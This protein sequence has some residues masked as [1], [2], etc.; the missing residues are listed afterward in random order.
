MNRASA[1]S[2]A[3]CVALAGLGSYWVVRSGGPDRDVQ[4]MMVRSEPADAI[5]PL[6]GE[7]ARIEAAADAYLQGFGRRVLVTN[8][9]L[10]TR[11]ARE[12]H[13]RT[14]TR[15]L[16]ERGVPRGAIE[17]VP[18]VAFTT[19]QEA[20]NVARFARAL[21]LT[22]LWIVTSPWHV[23][24]AELIFRD[25]FAGSDTAL[26]VEATVDDADEE[27][28]G[29]DPPRWLATGPARTTM[30]EV[31]KLAAYLLGVR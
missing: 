14:V 6:A 5:L 30:G 8:L 4:A 20:Q 25:V 22:S 27:A 13:V 1:L 18:G 24:R 12:L 15:L 29:Q 3:L 17:V 21:D 11:A 7:Q 9:P 26:A 2:I 10:A 19:Y 28:A 16:V 31:V 23:P